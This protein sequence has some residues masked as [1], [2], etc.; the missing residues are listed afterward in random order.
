M[1]PRSSAG[2]ISTT[3]ISS[4]GVSSSTWDIRANE[5]QVTEKLRVVT[6][7]IHKG[8]SQFNRR[9]VIHELRDGLSSLDPHLVFLQEVQGLNQRFAD[10]KSTRLNSSH[11]QIS[12][13]VFC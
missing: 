3:P 9:M 7:N 2:A 1:P 13:A 8:L 4:S 10:R 12:Y 11:S 6:L 5:A